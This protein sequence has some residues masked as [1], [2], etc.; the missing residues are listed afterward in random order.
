MEAVVR[1]N[2]LPMDSSTRL[3]TFLATDFVKSEEIEDGGNLSHV[4][5]R[6]EL[7]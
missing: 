1:S 3:F 7:P 6:E 5:V 4:V 2:G